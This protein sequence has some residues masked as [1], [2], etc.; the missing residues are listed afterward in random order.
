MEQI[1]QWRRFRKLLLRLII[2]FCTGFKILK[3][4][5][6]T[7]VEM[8]T[9]WIKWPTHSPCQKWIHPDGFRTGGQRAAFF[10][11]SHHPWLLND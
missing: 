7:F 6:C 9:G 1:T 8:A 4:K 10:C 3:L 2:R 11:A 5:Y